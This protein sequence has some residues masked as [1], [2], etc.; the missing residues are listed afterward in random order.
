MNAARVADSNRWY[1]E[2]YEEEVPSTIVTGPTGLDARLLPTAP[3]ARG[4][5]RP[6]GVESTTYEPPWR[7]V[8][9]GRLKQ[10]YR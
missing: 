9:W 1:I 4:V 5:S 8:T 6:G 2:R 10:I 7:S 3:S